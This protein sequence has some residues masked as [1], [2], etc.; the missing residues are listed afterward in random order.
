VKDFKKVLPLYHDFS[1]VVHSIFVHIH[2]ALDNPVM[3]E[4]SSV[5]MASRV[6]ARMARMR[7]F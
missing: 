3:N 1:L 5:L 6:I 7:E 2:P 4:F